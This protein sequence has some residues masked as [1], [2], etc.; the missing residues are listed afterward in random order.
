MAVR[1]AFALFD[2]VLAGD[3][4]R[5]DYCNFVERIEI[6]SLEALPW[7]HAHI[8]CVKRL[9]RICRIRKDQNSFARSTDMIMDFI[10]SRYGK[11]S[12]GSDRPATL[13]TGSKWIHLKH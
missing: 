7:S 9:R 3:E 5:R 10:S 8:I 6:D 2:S 1:F 4:Y 12:A 11:E 13:Q